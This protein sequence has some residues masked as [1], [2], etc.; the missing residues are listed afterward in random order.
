MSMGVS[1]VGGTKSED[2]RASTGAERERRANSPYKRQNENRID[3]T[4]GR[5]ATAER[6]DEGPIGEIESLGESNGGTR[7]TLRRG[8]D[9]VNPAAGCPLTP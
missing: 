5:R 1:R 6:D 2:S 7:T 4:S 3:V 9:R 8:P